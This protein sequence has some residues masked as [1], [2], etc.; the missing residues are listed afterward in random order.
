MTNGMCNRLTNLRTYGIMQPIVNID[1]IHLSIMQITYQEFWIL[2]QPCDKAEW[3]SYLK[4]W[5][6]ETYLKNTASANGQLR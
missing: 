6:R 4:F 1:I 2:Y 5:K 3:K